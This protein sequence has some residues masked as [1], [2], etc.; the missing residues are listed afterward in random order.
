MSGL[1]CLKPSP[2][3]TQEVLP[4]VQGFQP[5]FYRCG[6]QRPF[7]G[8]ITQYV[9]I[10]FLEVGLLQTVLF[11]T[12]QQAELAAVW[13]GNYR[14]FAGCSLLQES[15]PYYCEPELRV[16]SFELSSLPS[17]GQDPVPNSLG[18]RK[19]GL[20]TGQ[21]VRQIDFLGTVGLNALCTT[22][23]TVCASAYRARLCG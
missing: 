7:L 17:S 23:H 22:I 8:T 11:I 13:L 18:L 5:R 16:G 2:S 10:F 9:S 1:E 19:K 3:R 4:K 6:I 15:L 14:C 12:R 20:V 21:Y